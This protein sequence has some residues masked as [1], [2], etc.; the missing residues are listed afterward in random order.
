MKTLVL[1]ILALLLAIKGLGGS[2]NAVFLSLGWGLAHGPVVGTAIAILL[3]TFF[4]TYSQERKQVPFSPTSSE[5]KLF[6]L[7]YFSLI[8]Y[9]LFIRWKLLQSTPLDINRADMLFAIQSEIN[10]FLTGVNPYGPVVMA[11]GAT[12][13]HGYPPLLWLSYLPFS[14]I[15]LDLRYLNLLAQAVYYFFFWDIFLR[16]ERFYFL[17]F[18]K[19]AL[20]FLALIALHCFSKQAIRQTADVHTGPYWLYFTLFLWAMSRDHVKFAF[21]I[22]PLVC[23]CREPAILWFSPLLFYLFLERRELFYSAV[24][25]G[26]IVGALIAGPFIFWDPKL[27]FAGIF[28]Y[29]AHVYQTPVNE[30]LRFYGWSGVL[31][32]FGLLS[33]QKPLQA[34]GLFTSLILVWKKR[35]R[36]NLP[37]LLALGG[38]S[39]L[40]LMMV[41]SLSYPFIFSEV[42]L[43]VYALL[44]WPKGNATLLASK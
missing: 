29:G 31:A 20:L 2:F 36:L 38:F 18:K 43:L 5:K 23:L 39:Y 30:M 3:G 16:Q 7:I 21:W 28:F 40:T 44:F 19:S 14:V 34:S 9:A 25:K 17:S 41:V 33:L 8:G 13:Q 1:G 6:S 37:E 4:L 35:R 42:I 10:A 27:Y 12:V 11:N 15:N 32:T 24:I 22:L 26:I